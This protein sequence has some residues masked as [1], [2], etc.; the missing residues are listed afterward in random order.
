MV[1]IKTIFISLFLGSSLILGSVVPSSNELVDR[2]VVEPR[3]ADPLIG[4]QE[5]RDEK[6]KDYG[7][8]K[9]KSEYLQS[10]CLPLF[11]NSYSIKLWLR[12][13]FSTFP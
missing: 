7:H 8:G 5:K 4:D 10:S 12:Y 9:T 13:Y 1:A 2:Q 6:E 11:W 3:F